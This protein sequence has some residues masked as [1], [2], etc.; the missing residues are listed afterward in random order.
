MEMADEDLILNEEVM[1]NDI[2]NTSR[3]ISFSLENEWM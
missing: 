3:Q 2:I 1:F